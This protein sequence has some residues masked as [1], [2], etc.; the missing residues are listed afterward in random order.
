ME[1]SPYYALQPVIVLKAA[2]QLSLLSSNFQ[3][4]SLALGFQ[5]LKFEFMTSIISSLY[6]KIDA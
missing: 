6:L 2:H 3:S 4:P 1:A 5:L